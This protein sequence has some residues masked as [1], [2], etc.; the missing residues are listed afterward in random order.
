MDEPA[1]CVIRRGLLLPREEPIHIRR[2]R[3]MNQSSMSS[4]DEVLTPLH[5]NRTFRH[6]LA[7]LPAGEQRRR[8]PALQSIALMRA[9]PVV[10]AQ[11]GLQVVFQLRD[12]RVVR[13]AEGDT[14]QLAQDRALQAFDEAVR[15]RMARFGAAML[16]AQ[17]ATGRQEAPVE[18]RPA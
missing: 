16:D 7:D 17:L 4:V 10:E 1:T 9:L 5:S 13:S 15:P 18:L 8:R 2:C 3:L 6:W 14:P 12:A 11:V